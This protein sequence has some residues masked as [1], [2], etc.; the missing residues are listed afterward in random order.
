M[1][2][3]ENKL[4]DYESTKLNNNEK[5]NENIKETKGHNNHLMARVL[6]GLS[7]TSGSLQL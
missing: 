2:K 5:A 7:E 1:A 6:P 3:Q 4:K